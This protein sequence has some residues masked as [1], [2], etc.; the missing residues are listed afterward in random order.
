MSQS[1]KAIQ[2]PSYNFLL[3]KQMYSEKLTICHQGLNG[4]IETHQEPQVIQKKD[5]GQNYL[6]S[7]NT[8][9]SL[10]SKKESSIGLISQWMKGMSLRD[11]LCL[12]KWIFKNVLADSSYWAQWNLGN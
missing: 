9:I 11:I 2:Q 10:Y 6:L 8:F 4:W 5:T 1:P 3:Q 12:E 7:K